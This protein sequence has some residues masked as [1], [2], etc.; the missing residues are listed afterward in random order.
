MTKKHLLFSGNNA[1]GMYNFRHE[2]L[3]HFV[4]KGYRVSVSAPYDEEQ[5]RMLREL[6]CEVY[7]IRMRPR[8]TNPLHDF[9]LF[10]Q[11]YW[12][13]RKLKPDMSIT[14]TIKPNIYASWAA[15]LH[16]IPFLPVT[17]GLG[18][19]FLKKTPATSLAKR[20]YKHAFSKAERV[21]FLNSD[22]LRLFREAR[23]VSNALVEQLPGE[24]VNLDFFAETPMPPADQPIT[25]LYVGRILRDKGLEE[26]I[27]AAR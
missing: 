16:K 5:F 7:P 17:T 26:F 14:Y 19:V 13:M 8:G 18:Y 21:W 22:D 20:L 2:L 23:L 1:W 6:G 11:Y 15:H 27:Y 10:L 24:G 25:F 9:S 12:L 3:R 4:E